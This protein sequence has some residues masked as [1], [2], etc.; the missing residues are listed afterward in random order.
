MEGVAALPFTIRMFGSVSLWGSQ[1]FSTTSRSVSREEWFTLFRT[2]RTVRAPKVS[3]N[4][5][6]S[7][8]RF[9]N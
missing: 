4:G 2:S 3:G 8:A 6:L 5:K 7:G 9:N 1:I